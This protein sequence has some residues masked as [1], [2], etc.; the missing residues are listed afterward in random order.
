MQR[1][2]VVQLQ[3]LKFCGSTDADRPIRLRDAPSNQWIGDVPQ[4]ENDVRNEPVAYVRGQQPSVEI[5]L[6][7]GWF[8]PTD[9][10]VSAWGA[11]PAA[12]GAAHFTPIQVV[13]PY[14]V[15]L[16]EKDRR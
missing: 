14:R 9:F 1:Q 12:S 8:A 4:W 2:I 5:G 15:L 13:G 11:Q 10:Q 3:S 6:Q 7:V 16:T